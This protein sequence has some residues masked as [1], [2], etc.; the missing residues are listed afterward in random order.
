M[1]P[2]KILFALG[3]L[4]TLAAVIISVASL[5]DAKLNPLGAVGLGVAALALFRGSE[6]A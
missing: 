6:L 5:D 4:V 1:K 3:V 2:K